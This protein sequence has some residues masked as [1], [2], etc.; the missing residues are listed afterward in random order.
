[1][2]F[3]VGDKIKLKKHKAKDYTYV[4]E[5]KIYT[6]ECFY[7]DKEIKLKEL[8][9]KICF[10]EEDFELEKKE[11][12][13]HPSHYNEG[14]EAID[15]IESWNLNFSLGNAIKYIL[16]APYKSNTLE[17]LRKAKWYINREIEK[18]EKLAKEDK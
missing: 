8:S 7:G 16:R 2:S 4:K 14:I 13:N 17:D 9:N 18:L 10:Y 3:K 6:I 15:I 5:N 11:S 12:V 1:M